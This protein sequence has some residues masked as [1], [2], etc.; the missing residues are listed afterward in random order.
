MPP[1]NVAVVYDDGHKEVVRAG[2]PADLIAFADTF[3]KLGP[4]E[5]YAI[6]ELAWLVHRA[7]KLEQ[8]LAEWVETLEDITADE[9]EVAKVQEEL[10]AA[11]PTDEAGDEPI[12]LPAR[13]SETG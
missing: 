2:R 12:P 9:T 8:P 6:R 11:D 7:L 5:P 10:A 3:D 1:V 13:A 4:S